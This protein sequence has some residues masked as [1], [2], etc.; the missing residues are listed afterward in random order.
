MNSTSRPIFEST[1]LFHTGDQGYLTGRIPVLT[2][3]ANGALLA[4]WEARPGDAN[5]LA[6]DW[7]DI[8]V[9]FRRSEDDGAT[10]TPIAKLADGGVLPAH[11]T[12]LI[13]DAEGTIHLLFFINY[14][15]AFHSTSND[16]GRTFSAPK[17]ITAVFREFHSEYLWNVIAAGPGHGVV[18]RAGR[19]VV[20]VWLSNGGKHHRPSVAAAIYSDDCGRTWHRGGIVPPK[21][22]NM[23]ETAAVELEDGSVLFNVRSEDRAHRRAFSR[24]SD[25]GQS[26][27][28][29]ALDRQLKEPICMGNL[30][31]LNFADPSLETRGRIIFCNPDNDVYTG[32]FGPS[33]NGNKD[34]TNLTLKMSFDDCGTW[35]VSRVID[36]GIAGYCDLAHNGN[37]TIYVLYEKGGVNDSMWVNRS[38]SFVRLNI[39]WLMEHQKDAHRGMIV[40]DIPSSRVP[41]SV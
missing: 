12:N 24:S 33:W 32:K 36:A 11:N 28:Q 10:W 34:R 14:A 4:A 26:W 37:E 23:S 20:P 22:P 27:S 35:P 2:R 38:I 17:E 1:E 40:E 21:L 9:L 13:V 31:R 25:G 16:H 39:A 8:D 29:P 18:T 3:A 15:Y 6:G 7:E 30:L 5:G 19:I 41:A